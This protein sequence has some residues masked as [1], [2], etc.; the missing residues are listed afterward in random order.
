MTTT[1]YLIDTN[2]YHVDEEIANKAIE[3]K[4]G[5]NIKLADAV[6]AATAILNNLKIATRNVNDFKAIEGLG[7]TNPFD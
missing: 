5:M 6:I 4:R 7:A 1:D 3:L 2:I